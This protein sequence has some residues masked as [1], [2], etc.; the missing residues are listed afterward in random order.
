MKINNHSQENL[1]GNEV[2]CDNLKEI[3]SPDTHSRQKAQ[4]EFSN[5]SQEGVAS[6]SQNPL[7]EVGHPDAICKNCNKPKSSHFGRSYN[8]CGKFEELNQRKGR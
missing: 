5:D 6:Q 8:W 3:T 1:Q 7:N 4:L 2:G